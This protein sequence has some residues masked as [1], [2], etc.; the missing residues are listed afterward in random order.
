M[1]RGIIYTFLTQLPTLL[2]FFI[3]STLMTRMLAE[4]GRGI[5]ALFQNQIILL[6]LF[7]GLNIQL[8]ITYFIS[9]EEYPRRKVLGVGLALWII[10]ALLL[11]FL[12][13]GLSSSDQL[14]HLF[15][16]DSAT[17]WGYYAYV[18]VS[19]LLSLL[20][21]MFGAVFQGLRKFRI[22]NQMSILGSVLSA[23]GFTTLYLTIE[24]RT[25]P[26]NVPLVFSL[27]LGMLFILV[28]CWTILYVLHV[29]DVPT[30]VFRGPVWRAIFTFSLVGYLGTIINM[31]NYRFDVWVV[32]H[33]CGTAQLGLY[34]VAVG[35][36][37]LFFH[38]PEPFSKVVQ[39]FLYAPDGNALLHKFKAIARINFTVV[40]GGALVFG[41]TA[42]WIVPLLYGAN[43]GGAVL[44]LLFL[45]PGI[46]FASASKIMA[47]LVVQ[48]DMQRYNLLASAAGA[49][50]TIVLDL[51]LI[52]TMGIVGAAVASSL[53]YLVTFATV[54]LVI[55]FRLGIG[56]GDIFLLRPSDLSLLK[57]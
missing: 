44:P 30:P 37:Q 20:T 2:L 18:Y 46:V 17:H 1:K 36:G 45:L 50:V 15:L 54:C 26:E 48:R 28:L 4:E 33:F 14:R 29:K 3:G 12:L 56:I 24:G 53:A 7:L 40:L 51:L 35:L 19:V 49:V 9:K 43:F 16:P 52:P 5:H 31:V 41:A 42:G 39:P 27:A 23:V 55:R 38:I 13:F 47:L 34:S 8:G 57:R 22:L 11:P 10:N 32:E 21:N 6:T 25:G